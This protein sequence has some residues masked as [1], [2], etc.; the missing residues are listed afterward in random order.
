MQVALNL[1]YT[2]ALTN[3]KGTTKIGYINS[4]AT[5]AN[6][7]LLSQ[8]LI[9]LTSNTYGKTEKVVTSNLDTEAGE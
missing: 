4:A 1:T 2:T 3:Q 6:L 8:K 5:D 9:A 7:L